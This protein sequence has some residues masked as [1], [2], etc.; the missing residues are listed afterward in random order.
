M[1]KKVKKGDRIEIE[2]TGKLEDGNVFER[3][4]LEFT[5]GKGEVVEGLDKVVEDMAVNEEKSVTLGPEEAFGERR[6][7]FVI[8]FPRDKIPE[9]MEIEEDMIVELTDMYGNRI[10]GLVREVRED[11]LKIDLNHPLAGEHV[12]FDIKIKGI[13]EPAK[14]E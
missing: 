7:E 6:E 13:R 2:Y 11:A 8:D 12:T 4:D 1:D 10:P 5:V 14:E 9:S 3:S